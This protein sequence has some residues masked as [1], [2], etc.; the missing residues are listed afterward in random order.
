[1]G[2]NNCH[3]LALPP[4]ALIPMTCVQ[5]TEKSLSNEAVLTPSR[6][7]A[8]QCSSEV[9]PAPVGLGHA[10]TAARDPSRHCWGMCSLS[11]QRTI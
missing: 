7:G 11:G 6:S 4:T 10:F 8:A 2:L 5:I 3:R 1:M 9:S